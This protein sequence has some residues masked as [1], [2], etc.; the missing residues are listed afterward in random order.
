MPKTTVAG[1]VAV[2]VETAVA[3]TAAVAVAAA[4]P[5][6]VVVALTV[7][8]MEALRSKAKVLQN[9]LKMKTRELTNPAHPTARR[10]SGT[11]RY[12]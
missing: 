12:R 1:V 7:L 8:K 9:L 5:V 6:A 2:A 4:V 10:R 3:V 11:V